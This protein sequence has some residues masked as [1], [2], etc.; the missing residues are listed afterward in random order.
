[1]KNLEM[2]IK[3][4]LDVSG[5]VTTTVLNAKIGKIENKIPD[6]S[7]LVTTTFLMQ[8]SEKLRRKYEV[9]VV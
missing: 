4:T 8:K 7:S 5:V 9:L 3:K 1:M 6:I 2:L